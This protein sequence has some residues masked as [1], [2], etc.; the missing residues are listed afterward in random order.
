VNYAEL[1]K[2]GNELNG[3]LDELAEGIENQD[4]IL[5]G[6]LLEYELPEHFE[7]LSTLIREV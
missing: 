6:D 4:M 3:L 5:L 1:E 7:K 2:A